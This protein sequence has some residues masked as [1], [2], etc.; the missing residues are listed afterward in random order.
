LKAKAVSIVR[1]LH[2]IPGRLKAGG[3][4]IPYRGL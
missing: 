3:L 1:A 2:L 4:Q